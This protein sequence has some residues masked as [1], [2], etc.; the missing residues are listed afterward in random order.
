MTIRVERR[1][2]YRIGVN[3]AF[4]SWWSSLYWRPTKNFGRI[5]FT[6]DSIFFCLTR[7]SFPSQ[8]RIESFCDPKEM[9]QIWI[10]PGLSLVP[11]PGT[12]ILDMML[13]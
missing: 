13:L 9:A 7:T 10:W 3:F 2:S 8:F 12:G 11:Y 1:S 4:K 5:Y 6:A